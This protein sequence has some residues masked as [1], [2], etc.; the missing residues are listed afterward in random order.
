[1]EHVPLCP[2]CPGSK[3]DRLRPGAYLPLRTFRL[4]RK[5]P[6]QNLRSC[7]PGQ[8]PRF[9]VFGLVASVLTLVA[10]LLMMRFVPLEQLD[11]QLSLGARQ[12]LLMS[13]VSMLVFLPM[14]PGFVTQIY[15][16]K[17]ASCLRLVRALCAEVHEGWLE[18]HRYLNMEYLKEQKKELQT[19]A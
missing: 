13:I 7:S 1:M 4:F 6:D 15:P 14:I 8:A 10:F 9:C 16:L 19:A 3:F 5:V 11:V 18:N 2:V 12:L 17:L